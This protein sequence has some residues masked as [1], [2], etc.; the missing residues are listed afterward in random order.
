MLASKALATASWVPALILFFS[1]AAPA[2]EHEQIRLTS[3]EVRLVNPGHVIVKLGPSDGIVSSPDAR[4]MAYVARLGGKQVVVVDGVE[5]KPYDW[6]GGRPVFSPDSKHIAYVAARLA[7]GKRSWHVV[8]D[9]VE[10]KEYGGVVWYNHTTNQASPFSPDSRRVAYIA[11]HTVQGAVVPAIGSGFVVSPDGYLLTC[12]HVVEGAGVIQ[13]TIGGATYNAA[14]VAS[15][16]GS[17][18]ALVK[19]DSR[20]LP[21]LYLGD[22]DRVETGTDVHILGYPKSSEREDKVQIEHG[23][24]SGRTL[25]RFSQKLL[26]TD[27]SV[28]PGNSGGPMVNDRGE[29]VGI[30]NAKLVGPGVAKVGFAIPTSGLREWLR[31]HGV[32]LRATPG[33]TKPGAVDLL[34][35]VAPAVGLFSVM[36]EGNMSLTHGQFN[37]KPFVVVDDIEGKEYGDILKGGH[38]NGGIL[39]DLIWSQDGRHLGYVGWTASRRHR[40][41][42]DGAEEAFQ[43]GGER[44][45]PY[46][47]PDGSRTAYNAW[48]HGNVAVVDGKPH[49]LRYD[50][51][52]SFVSHPGQLPDHVAFV[53]SPDSKRVAY[54]AR[55]GHRRLVVLDGAEGAEY[56][57]ILPLV[58]SPDSKRLAYLGAREVDS[59]KV[60]QV[61]RGGNERGMKESRIP[62]KES[63]YYLVVHGADGKADE[64]ALPRGRPTTPV[65]SA[66]SSRLAYALAYELPP[67]PGKWTP[68]HMRR[69]TRVVVDGKEEKEYMEAGPP[70]F[71]LDSRHVAYWARVQL[72]RGPVRENY[73]VVRDGVEGKYYPGIQCLQFSPDG[74][75]MAYV[76]STLPIAVG[77]DQFVVWDGKEGKHYDQIDNLLFSPDGRHLVYR[78]YERPNGLYQWRFVV[79]GAEG[80]VCEVAGPAA[81][82]RPPV[83]DAPD[84][85][86]FLAGPSRIDVKIS[87]R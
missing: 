64:L 19:I 71:S 28:N 15:H 25:S 60:V 47:S 31:K 49:P 26:Q 21:S 63:K 6:I 65:F 39:S 72:E 83:F 27:A 38:V 62:A 14:V 5:G 70:V 74:L 85:F 16:M 30:V 18:L 61:P 77:A 46:F 53:F 40:L 1:T 48:D 2:A 29:V 67:E 75:H 34:K 4:H 52:G 22:S 56:D 17:D 58:F 73:V 12:A 3:Q 87:A 79:D 7:K 80:K 59:F 42:V 57:E 50:E 33:P 43:A 9:G 86:H 32:D 44:P 68:E 35:E 78:A 23:V 76:A 8:V 37:A 69:R 41:V 36:T 11:T 20:G 82:R 24:I 81:L 45:R 54:I 51:I 55:R 66:D 10:G 13:T 84:A